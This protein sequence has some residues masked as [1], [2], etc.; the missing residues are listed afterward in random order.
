MV[1]DQLLTVVIPVQNEEKNLPL[2]L[3]SVKDFK[4]VVIV[5]SGS[6]D[7]TCDIAQKYGREVVQFVWNGEFPKKRN[8]MLRNYKFKT[9][10]VLFLD[11]DERVTEKFVNPATAHRIARMAALPAE[12]IKPQAIMATPL[13]TL[14]NDWLLGECDYPATHTVIRDT[15]HVLVQR[16]LKVSYTYA[17]KSMIS[18]PLDADIAVLVPT[19]TNTYYLYVDVN[20]EGFITG[21]NVTVLPPVFGYHRLSNSGDFFNLS[22]YDMFDK[23]NNAIRRVYI[24]R[25]YVATGVVTSLVNVPLGTR[26]VVPLDNDLILSARYILDNPFM[27]DLVDVHAEVIYRNGWQRTEWNDQIGVT[28]A[29]HPQFGDTQIVVQCGQMGFLA[30]GRESGSSFGSSFTT[31]TN[32]LRTRIVIERKF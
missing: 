30:C 14:T 5:D 10:W 26:Y 28:A 7:S 3:D 23:N 24:S 22:T 16:G 20:A 6:T 8:W 32:N 21:A 4:H 15:T 11:A 9:P 12:S 31:I 1:A 17:H 2:C 13:G 25:V 18:E 19:E 29:T 27:T